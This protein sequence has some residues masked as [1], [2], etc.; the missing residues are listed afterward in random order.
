MKEILEATG[1]FRKEEIGVALELMEMVTEEEGQ[2]EYVMFVST[3]E[4]RLVRGYYCVGPTPMTETSFDLYWIAVDPKQYGSG[5]SRELLDH[6][7]SYVRS[8]GGKKII[9]ETSSQ[10][11]YDRTR[12]FYGKHG[13]AEEARIRNYYAPGDDLV[14]YTKQL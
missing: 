3:D 4:H 6:C 5:V 1:V 10:S 7:E 11:G 14:I 12:S 9:A 2:E 13:F 8:R